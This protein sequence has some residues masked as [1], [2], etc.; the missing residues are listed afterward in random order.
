MYIIGK[1]KLKYQDKVFGERKSLFSESLIVP[2]FIHSNVE[3]LQESEIYVI[4]KQMI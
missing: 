4:N 2:I 1:G 3:A